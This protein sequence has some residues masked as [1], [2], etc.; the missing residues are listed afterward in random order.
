[1][2]NN[3]DDNTQRWSVAHEMPKKWKASMYLKSIYIHGFYECIHS[4]I[5]A[6]QIKLRMGLSNHITIIR[7]RETIAG[8]EIKQISKAK[9]NNSNYCLSALNSFHL[10]AYTNIIANLLI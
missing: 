2:F 5:T 3:T 8:I 7:A 6:L 1:M 4:Q 9:F 10:T